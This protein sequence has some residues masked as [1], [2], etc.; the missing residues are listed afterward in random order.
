MVKEIEGKVYKTCHREC[1]LR[2]E[3][4]MVC[5]MSGVGFIDSKSSYESGSMAGGMKIILQW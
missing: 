3:R 4:A 1:L 5:I 2:A